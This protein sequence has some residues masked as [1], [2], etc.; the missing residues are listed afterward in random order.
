MAFVQ[1]VHP[2]IY[3]RLLISRLQLLSVPW[4]YYQT[5]RSLF[6]ARSKKVEIEAWQKPVKPVKAKKFFD[7]GYVENTFTYDAAV[8][9]I[10]V[11]WC[12]MGR[13]SFAKINE[14]MKVE[15]S[16]VQPLRRSGKM[17]IT[18]CDSISSH[19]GSG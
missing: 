2:Y 8:F 14:E 1:R 13:K 16:Q 17:P 18:L 11:Y 9:I 5:F 19:C 3:S 6:P 12:S 15:Q 10:I 4:C 7:A